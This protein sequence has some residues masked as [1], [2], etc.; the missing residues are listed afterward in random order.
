[1]KT[2]NGDLHEDSHHILNKSK[3]YF[4]QLLNMHN[5]RDVRK[6]EV[7]MAEPLVPGPSHLE[8]KAKYYCLR[9]TNSLILFGIRKNCLI[10]GRSLLLYQFTKRVIK[11]TVIIVT[12]MNF[13]QDFIEYP[14]RTVKIFSV[15]FDIYRLQE[16]L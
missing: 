1:V 10:S 11:L 4:S 2:E 8:V 16:S 13:I 3:N 9:S 15:G 6:M 12:A 14:P 7:H 5:V